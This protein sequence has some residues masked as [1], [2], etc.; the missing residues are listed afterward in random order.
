VQMGSIV[1]IAVY[2]VLFLD[3]N[4][5]GNPEHKPFEGIRSWFFGLTGDIWTKDQARKS[6]AEETTRTGTS[7][8]NAR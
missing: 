4:S 6:D 1:F 7:T 8:S 5:Q 3:W 2:G